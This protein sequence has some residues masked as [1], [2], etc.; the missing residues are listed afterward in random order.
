MWKW[1][2]REEGGEETFII[3]FSM[4]NWSIRQ[5]QLKGELGVKKRVLRYCNAAKV[6]LH[7]ILAEL[8]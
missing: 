5:I 6:E 7:I 4:L 3:I 8:P 1:K 2:T